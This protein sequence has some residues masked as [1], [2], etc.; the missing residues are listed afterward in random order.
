MEPWKEAEI[1]FERTMA[2]SYDFHYYT[3]PVSKAHLHEFLKLVHRYAL[4]DQVVLDV[5]GG[6]GPVAQD[7]VEKGYKQVVTV[8]IS[9]AMLREAK[10]KVPAVT[11]I[12]CD[13]EHLP[14][15]EESISTVVCSSVLHHMPAPEGVLQDIRRVLAPHGMLIAQEPGQDHCLSQPQFQEASG[16]SMGLMHYLYRIEHFKPIPEPPIHEYHRAFTRSEVVRLFTSQL[17]V[18]HFRSRFAFSSL[19]TKL[20][21]PVIASA[22]LAMDRLLARNEGAVFHVVCGKEGG[23]RNLLKNYFR[24]L[25]QLKAGPSRSVSPLFMVALLPLIALGRC[26]ELYQRIRSKLGRVVY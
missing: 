21:S 17:P 13:G 7:L 20:K 12:V 10:K 16:L 4:K 8:D 14:F 26:Y 23:H 19:F 11:A 25:D 22:V 1:A 5:G 3:S 2:G 15:K 18:V 6:T 24:V 9:L